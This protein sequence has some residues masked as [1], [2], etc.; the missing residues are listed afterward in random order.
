MRKVLLLVG[1]LVLSGCGGESYFE[2]SLSQQATFSNRTRA[3]DTLAALPI[4]QQKIPVVVYEFQDQTGQFRYNDRITDYSS[5]VTKGGYAILINAM[6]KAGNKQWFT[7]IERGG[8]KNLLQ[9]RQIIKA[10]RLQYEG[11][12]GKKMSDIPPL[13]Y[14]GMLIEGG[15]ISYDTN[16][17]TGG[18]GAVWLGVGNSVQYRQDVVTVYLR[19]VNVQSGEVLL[20]V[21]AAKT[22]YSASVDS[23]VLKYV[24]TDK[25]FQAEAG[26]TVNEPVQLAVRQ[27]IE[28]GVYALIME[29]ALD[30]L[31]TFANKT[32]G[33]E[34]M[35]A[36]LE[37]RD[38]ALPTPTPAS[39]VGATTKESL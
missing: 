11:P 24:S 33:Q 10:T 27:A 19:A 2:K 31:W 29:G 26:F 34:A 6:L 8:L 36:Y 18:A 32:K 16:T 4:P 1:C 14:G 20:S 38:D 5:A 15:I 35:R 12:G 39:A 17:V 30:N 3:S 21:T 7:V 37:R 28:T 13:L 9:E 23:N 25:L 22:V